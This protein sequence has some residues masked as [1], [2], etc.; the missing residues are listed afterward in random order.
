LSGEYDRDEFAR[1]IADMAATAN[2]VQIGC[3][4]AAA[5]NLARGEPVDLIVVAQA[6]PSQ[7]PL[8]EIDALRQA[9]P[10]APIVALLGSWCEGEMRSGSPWPGVVRVHW[11]QWREWF[12][13]GLAKFSRGEQSAWS[14]PMTA[15]AEE[16]LLSLKAVRT[17][18]SA[19]VAVIS[20]HL[21]MAD[22]LAAACRNR[23]ASV[24]TLNHIPCSPI[25]GVAIVLWDVGLLSPLL[26]S[27][28]QTVAAQ[29]PR[30]RIIVLADFPRSEEVDRLI[31]AGA[32]AVLSKPLL[33]NDLDECLNCLLAQ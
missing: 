26:V 21:E 3:L 13:Q 10:L 27:Q 14:Q 5:Q 33:V 17:D 28:Q 12:R 32:A 9:A 20:E 4:N 31:D 29:F 16:R 6:R 2:V 22:W 23:G 7:F 1:A 8:A 30:S 15:T 18:T 24:I 19:V 25:D 11:H